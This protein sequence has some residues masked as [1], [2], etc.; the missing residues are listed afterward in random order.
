M[1]RVLLAC[2]ISTAL[3]VDQTEREKSI[4]TA[5]NI[6]KVL[7]AQQ[8]KFP[9]FKKEIEKDI[10]FVEDIVTTLQEKPKKL[11]SPPP[12]PTPVEVRKKL[13]PPPPPPTEKPKKTLVEELKEVQLK[14]VAAEQ[15]APREEPPPPPPIIG[16]EPPSTAEVIEAVTPVSIPLEEISQKLA[17][18]KEVA[19][20]ARTKFI[21]QLE[22]AKPHSLLPTPQ[23]PPG[24]PETPS[25]RLKRETEEAVY[26]KDE[27]GDDEEELPKH[28]TPVPSIAPLDADSDV[29][30][31]EPL[32]VPVLTSEKSVRGAGV[33]AVTQDEREEQ[34]APVV[35]N[36]SA[37]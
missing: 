1:R 20:Q 36:H 15:I 19:R 2:I 25:Q 7:R 11:E 26:E 22:P 27:N 12:L 21:K 30:D 4:Q 14:K 29:P 3:A 35:A 24:I 9:L 23:P 37:L 32:K 34:S 16:E 6:Q 10:Q 31:L 28:I 8:A 18:A 17:K 5:L 33:H 13:A